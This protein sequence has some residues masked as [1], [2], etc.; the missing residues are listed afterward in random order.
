LIVLTIFVGQSLYWAQS[1]QSQ[2]VGYRRWST[3]LSILSSYQGNALDKH[4][5]LLTA[6]H[7]YQSLGTNQE[8]RKRAYQAL[9]EHHIPALTLQEIHNATNKA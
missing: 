9:L 5:A 3:P 2:S 1:C 4:I 8:E 7:C 6:H